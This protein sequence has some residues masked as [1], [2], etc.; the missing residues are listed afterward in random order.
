MIFCTRTL[1]Q[2]VPEI[3]TTVKIIAVKNVAAFIDSIRNKILIDT[4]KFRTKDIIVTGKGKMNLKSYSPLFFVNILYQY[5]LDIV[6]GS[7]VLAFINE[8]LVPEKIE[9]INLLNEPK[10]LERFGYNGRNGVVFIQLKEVNKVKLEIAGFKFIRSAG[11]NF[12]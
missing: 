4:L 8:I 1:S 7:D 11:N 5:K 6:D 3:D 12:H 9:N 10:S 2:N